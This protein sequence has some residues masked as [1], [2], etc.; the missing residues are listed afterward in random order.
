MPWLAALRLTGLVRR[1]RGARDRRRSRRRRLQPGVSGLEPA[2]RAVARWRQSAD[3]TGAHGVRRQPAGG[4]RQHER[5]PADHCRRRCP[6]HVQRSRDRCERDLRKQRVEQRDGRQRRLRHGV[7]GHVQCQRHHRQ[8]HDRREL[9]V[10]LGLVR[11]DQH[12]GGDAGNAQSRRAS[13]SGGTGVDA[14]QASARG[15]GA[16]CERHARWRA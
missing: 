13:E 4:A 15:E 1:R 11:H 5:V 3:G 2:Q 8:L 7:G 12:R 6:G 16:R 10:R 9:C 14:L